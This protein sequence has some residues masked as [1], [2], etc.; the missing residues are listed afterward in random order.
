MNSST[1]DVTLG[2]VGTRDFRTFN[3]MA[4]TARLQ[5]EMSAELTRFNRQD[6]KWLEKRNEKFG[7][8][9]PERVYQYDKR[10]HE[11]AL[12]RDR[13]RAKLAGRKGEK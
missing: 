3:T 1:A 7:L 10:N 13:L 9:D 5:S 6:I 8:N 4:H 11:A 12:T 2:T